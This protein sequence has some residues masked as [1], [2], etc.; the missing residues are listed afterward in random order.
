MRDYP[1]E[2]EFLKHYDASKYDRP[3]VSVDTLVFTVVDREPSNYRKLPEKV[4]RALLIKR[5]GHPHKGKWA[6]PGG[7]INMD[8]NLEAA[9]LRE[10]KEETN[11]DN[12]YIEQLYTYGDVGRDPRTRVISCTYLALTDSEHIE[13]KAGDDAG[14]A[15]WFDVSSKLIEE[16][17][18]M[19][20]DGYIL[21]K[22][23]R[24]EL[25]N[26]QHHLENIVQVTIERTGKHPR[27]KREIISSP[28]LAFDHATIIQYG[29]ERLRNKIEYTDIAFNLVGEYFTLTE[30]QQVYEVILDKELLKANFR[31]KIADMVIETNRM[32]KDAGHRPS[33]LYQFNPYWA[34][35]HFQGRD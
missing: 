35:E 22:R 13:L 5:N 25:K 20:E 23:Y 3:S 21:K 17:R 7:F 27:I 19:I 31:R 4:L 15:M 10:L 18:T 34:D 33:K 30:L 26:D 11:I 8:E 12:V 28:H 14:D 2:E 29:L 1:S 16:Q 24:L 6:L 9:A 32:K